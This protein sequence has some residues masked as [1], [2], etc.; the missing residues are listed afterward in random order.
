MTIR[1]NLLVQNNH[2]SIGLFDNVVGNNINVSG[3]T[4]RAIRVHDNAMD[5]DL[6][7]H[8][9][10]VTDKVALRRND[11]G[12]NL[13]CQGNSPDPIFTGNTPGNRALGECAAP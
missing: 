11:I 6:L 2:G 8:N 7:V 13:N 10:T 3:N 4:G 9:N 12:I 5:N 1:N